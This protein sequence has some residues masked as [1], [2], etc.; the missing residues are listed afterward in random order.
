MSL[1]PISDIYT[2][3]N[4]YT[5]LD[6]GGSPEELSATL[7]NYVDN[8]VLVPASYD[9]EVDDTFDFTVSN[10]GVYLYYLDGAV[11]GRVATGSVVVNHNAKEKIFMIGAR[12]V[13]NLMC[14][15]CSCSDWMKFKG[16]LPTDDTF[17]SCQDADLA[18]RSLNTINEECGNTNVKCTCG[19]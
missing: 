13:D 15:R 19:C 12:D 11:S 5:R 16:L 8:T 4:T 9:K 1:C 2:F 18:V 3:T 10:D 6:D 14:G 7:V 17:A